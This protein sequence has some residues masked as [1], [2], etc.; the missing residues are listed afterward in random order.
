MRI[1]ALAFVLAL[2]SPL[3][4]G[5]EDTPQGS[6]SSEKA[7]AGGSTA[8]K[9]S[10]A[11]LHQ[12]DVAIIAHHHQL[13][14]LEIDY[15]KLAQQRGTGPVQRYGERLMKDHQK[16]D[17]DLTALAKKHGL[18]KIPMVT[19]DT[20]AAQKEQQDAKDTMARISKLEGAEFD[21]E[22]LSVMVMDHEREIGKT[23]NAIAAARSPALA[24]LLRNVKPVLQR[25][26]DSAR[27]L[28]KGAPQVGALER[29]P[30]EG[31]RPVEN[32]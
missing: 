29:S 11:K 6:K 10:A 7:E 13:H 18:S 9:K 17:K 28:Q 24:S 2:A 16:L 22:F 4:A 25:H 1:Y 3:T 26:A 21:R 32:R 20:E 8:K 30:T 12:D 27:E 5:A 31:E 23:E 19:P 15:G 14:M